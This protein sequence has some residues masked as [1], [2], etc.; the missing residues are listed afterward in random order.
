MDVTGNQESMEHGDCQGKRK[1]Q[2]QLRLHMA[3][4]AANNISGLGTCPSEHLYQLPLSGFQEL[5]LSFILTL[6]HR[7]SY[8]EP[9]RPW[10]FCLW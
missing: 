10:R 4:M 1:G 5:P 8:W 3:L 9:V 7:W 2:P 6:S